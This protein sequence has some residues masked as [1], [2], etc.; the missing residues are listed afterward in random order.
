MSDPNGSD[1]PGGHDA[2]GDVDQGLDPTAAAPEASA[3]DETELTSTEVDDLP[4]VEELATG[5]TDGE[6]EDACSAHHGVVDV[7]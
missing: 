7:E 2:A 3:E 1:V 4:S 5:Q 6:V